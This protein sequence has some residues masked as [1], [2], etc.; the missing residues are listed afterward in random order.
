L[1]NTDYPSKK[2]EFPPFLWNYISANKHKTQKGATPYEDHSTRHP[3]FL[4]GDCMLRPKESLQ[5]NLFEFL[6][7]PERAKLNDEPAKVMPCWMA[8]SSWLHRGGGRRPLPH[9]LQ[10]AGEALISLLK[11]KCSPGRS[12]SRGAGGPG[13][14]IG[15][16][17]PAHNLRRI[18]SLT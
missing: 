11:R 13:S 15:P 4:R 1:K 17:I 14:W 3:E 2:Q 5:M 12:R 10:S 6:L 7:A 18:A 8:R 16:G 9:G